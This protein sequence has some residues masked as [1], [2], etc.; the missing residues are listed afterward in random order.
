MTLNYANLAKGADTILKQVGMTVSVIRGTT[1]VASG[2]GVFV[3][4]E[5]KNEMISTSSLRAQTTISTKTL[6]LSGFAKAPAV[7][8]TVLVDKVTYVIQGIKL[9]RPTT[10]TILYKLEVQ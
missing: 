3:E 5:S 6:L 9:V 7:G 10:T 1:K 4:S 8:D 2:Y